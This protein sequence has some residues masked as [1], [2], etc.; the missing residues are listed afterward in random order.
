[1]YKIKLLYDI[2]IYLFIVFNYFNYYEKYIFIYIFSFD[3]F[4]EL[5]FYLLIY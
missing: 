3:N 2:E 4:V 5:K 1:M